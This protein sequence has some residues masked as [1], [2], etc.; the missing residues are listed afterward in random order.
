VP[1]NNNPKP[2]LLNGRQREHTNKMSTTRSENKIASLVESKNKNLRVMST[3]LSEGRENSNEYRALEQAVADA[4][5]DIATLRKLASHPAIIAVQEKQATEARD[6]QNDHVAAQTASTVTANVVDAITNNKSAAVR[7]KQHEA[8]RSYLKTGSLQTRDLAT[9]SDAGGA[10]VIPQGYTFGAF[11]R[12]YYAP[13]LD[14]LNEVRTESG[15]PYK[16]SFL[17]ATTTPGLVLIQEAATSNPFTEEDPLM[18]SSVVF[19]DLFSS[20]Q[21]NVSYQEL[22]DA[23]NLDALLTRIGAQRYGQG[24]EAILTGGVDSSSTATPNNPGLLSGIQSGLTF[25][26]ATV[27]GGIKYTDF[28]STLQL[29]DAAYLRSPKAAV[30]MHESTRLTLASQLDT[31]GRPVWNPDPKQAFDSIL[32]LPIVV[33]NALSAPTAGTFTADSLPILVGDFGNYAT[34]RTDGDI[35]VRV[36]RERRAEFL[37][38]LVTFSARV[39]STICDKKAVAALKIAAS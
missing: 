12:K 4:E 9:T 39:G 3:L 25:Q 31:T 28:I 5:E 27:A 23:D 26:T 13:L 22:D 16:I 7:A 20:G 17:N 15:Q 21:I 33:N 10:A 6:R 1:E 38:A 37:E 24:L 29:L 19:T 8:F 30:M 36:S 2:P 35:R 32:G 34:V 18:S 14:V 11:A